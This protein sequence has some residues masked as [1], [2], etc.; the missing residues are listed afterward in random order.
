[1]DQGIG[2]KMIGRILALRL[3]E[4]E[5]EFLAV[6]DGRRRLL[7][8]EHEDTLAVRNDLGVLWWETGE[9]AKAAAEHREVLAIR[10]RL[11]GE[12]DQDVVVSMNNLALAPRDTGCLVE[13][14]AEQRAELA[15]CRRMWGDDDVDTLSSHLNL[16]EILK[17][18]GRWRR[19]R[20]RTGRS[21]RPSAASWARNIR[22][23]RLAVVTWVCCGMPGRAASGND[24]H[25]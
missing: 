3:E 18:Q 13:A 15:L 2:P 4:A 20:R 12:E 23:P 14:E 10:R 22:K 21:W 8:E 24:G 9:P 16:A 25:R 7:G 19:P 1:M 5:Q 11:L 17:L 6:L